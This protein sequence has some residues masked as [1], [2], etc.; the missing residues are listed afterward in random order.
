MQL[1]VENLD[2]GVRCLHLSGRLD[3]K[4]TQE[5][6]AQFAAEAGAQKTSV[7]VDFSKVDYIAS[8]GIRL[9]LSNAKTLASRGTKLIILKPQK[10]VEDVL[11][12]AGLDEVLAIEHDPAAAR[13]LLASGTNT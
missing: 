7:L 3:F 6:E 13:A 10:M 1:T 11:C 12:M 5:V 9:L 2:A 8:V 4:G